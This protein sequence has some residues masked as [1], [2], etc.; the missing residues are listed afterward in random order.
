MSRNT[1][2]NEDRRVTTEAWPLTRAMPQESADEQE[3]EALFKTHYQEIYRLLYRIT[4]T[5]EEAEDLA[6]ETFL[7]L[8]RAPGVSNR[9]GRPVEHAHSGS[10]AAG[11]RSNIRAWLYRVASNLAFNHLRGEGRRRQRQEAVARQTEV[12]DG[13][14]GDPAETALRFEEQSRVRRA[15]S[16]LPQRQ[17]QLLLLRYAGLSYRELAAAMDIA[18]GSVGTMLARAGAAFERSYQDMVLAEGGG[19]HDV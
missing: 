13:G 4:G 2:H 10:H 12:R 9:Q 8:H 18:F 6:Q 5:R 7:R 14:I 11:E 1:H 19:Q 16:A 3:F 15:L 17:A